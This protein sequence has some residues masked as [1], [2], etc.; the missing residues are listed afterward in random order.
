[1]KINVIPSSKPVPS[2]TRK[3]YLAEPGLVATSLTTWCFAEWNQS[4][5]WGDAEVRAYGPLSMD[6]ASMVFHY[7]QEIFEGMK[8]IFPA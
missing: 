6:P 3:S 7:G 4:S 2:D 8:A 5:G 1:M